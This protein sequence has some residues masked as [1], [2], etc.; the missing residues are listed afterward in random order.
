LPVIPAKAGIQELQQ[1]FTNHHYQ[2]RIG[3]IAA[4]QH[5]ACPLDSGFR[6]NDGMIPPEHIQANRI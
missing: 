4:S 2:Q 6:E 1:K 5:A 3:P